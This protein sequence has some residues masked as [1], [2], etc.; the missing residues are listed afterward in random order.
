MKK[1]IFAVLIFLA[2]LLALAGCNKDAIPK[3]YTPLVE[4]SESVLVVVRPDSGSQTEKTIAMDLK[5]KLSKKLGVPVTITVDFAFD[6]SKYPSGTYFV[7]VGSTELEQTKSFVKNQEDDMYGV[8]LDENMIVVESTEDI[9]LELAVQQFMEAV[10]EKKGK[11]YLDTDK[12]DFTSGKLETTQIVKNGSTDYT[13]VCEETEVLTTEDTHYALL[14]ADQIQKS[15]KNYFGADITWK[16]DNI[17]S[18]GKEIIIGECP[19]RDS[20]ENLV[21][22]LSYDEYSISLDKDGNVYLCG[23]NYETTSMAVEKFLEIARVLKDDD[24]FEFSNV[25]ARNYEIYDTPD[26]PLFEDSKNFR[27]ISSVLGS[28]TLYYTETNVDRFEGYLKTLAGAGFEQIARNE[29]NENIFTTY[30]NDE[31][32]VNCYYTNRN[33]SIRICVDNKKNTAIHNYAPQDV[34]KITTPMLIQFTSGC[35]YLIRLEDGSFIVFDGGLSTK[36]NYDNLYNSLNK[37]NVTGGRPLIRAWIFSHPHS[38]HLGGFFGFTENYYKTV[39]IEQ[40]IYNNPT[41]AHYYSTIDDPPDGA[42][43]LEDRID[44][45]LAYC[46]KYYPNA[47]MVTAHTGQTM[48]F[49][50][51]KAEILHTHE[52]DFPK[53]IS[54]GNQIS[55]LIRFTFGDQTILFTGD[56]HENSAPIIVEMFGSYLKSDIVQMPHHCYNGGTPKFYK[57]VEAKVCLVTNTLDKYLELK[58]KTQNQTGVKLADQVLVPE[59]DKDIIA[60]EL[61]YKSADGEKWNRK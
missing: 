26:V 35:G 58:D 41:R 61:P 40:F 11:Y 33:D 17:K 30:Q 15:F 59:S 13:I 28:F 21:A 55:L 12:L 8:K 20:S 53:H 50:N 23:K 43:I 27:L 36:T 45:F 18:Q 46:H 56:M 6:E 32:V 14:L 16:D 57:F 49:G 39:D 24:T 9:Y 52:D 51:T 19:R 31:A 25:L 4:N 37:Y 5:N 48:Y 42:T 10:V 22:S 60:F 29:I 2:T 47:D 34:N 1:G 54:K 3:S 7:C 38:D 44:K